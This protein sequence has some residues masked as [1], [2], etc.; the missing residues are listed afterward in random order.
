[1]QDE[2][3][4]GSLELALSKRIALSREL[5]RGTVLP[6]TQVAFASGF[7]SVRRFN[8]AY[9][10]SQGMTPSEVRRPRVSG[11]ER[12]GALRVVLDV[13]T[14]FDAASAFAF[15]AA[16]AVQGGELAAKDSYVRAVALG[17][18][19]GTVLFRAAPERDA[20]V[21]EVSPAL[22]PRLM[23]IAA[24]AR[25][26]FDTDADPLQIGAHLAKDPRLTRAV[27]RRP[28]LRVMGAFEPFEWAV[29][30]V[31]G[32]QISVRAALT[33][34]ARLLA[35]LGQPV[36]YRAG[37]PPLYAWPDAARLAGARPATLTSLGLTTARA[38]TLLGVARAV[39][40]GTLVLDRGADPSTT[41]EALLAL[42]G[43][44]PWTAQYIELRALG[45]PD[46]F[47]A[48]DLGLRKAL[49]G[50]STAQCEA[51]AERW[52]PWRAY[53]ATHHWLG[54]SERKH[55]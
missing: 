43:V 44:G 15:L 45:W 52:R 2:L 39:A 26:L 20:L 3:G 7:A 46:A 29:R 38:A 13:R 40:D 1:M 16:R 32:Q 10:K 55:D 54:L 14:P 11:E 25:R 50:I 51:R 34:A 22:S 36:R 53:A 24:R 47:P 4:V 42:P 33:L 31:L 49:G 28:A 41:R 18:R 35:K 17:G 5:L 30:A 48:G 23:S 27:Q 37:A 9:R 21:L 12:D 19:A 6:V 8:D